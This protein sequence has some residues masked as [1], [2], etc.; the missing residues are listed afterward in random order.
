MTN[1]RRAASNGVRVAAATTGSST[2]A[3]EDPGGAR[4]RDPGEVRVDAVLARA[5]ARCRGRR[6]PSASSAA[7]NARAAA[8]LPLPAGAVEEVGVRGARPPAAARRAEDGAG[9]GMAL[10]RRRAWAPGTVGSPADGRPAGDDRG[11]RRRGQDDA[12][13][14]ARR[15]ARRAGRRARSCC[16]SPA[17]SSSPSASATLVKDPALRVGA[18]AEALMYAAARAQLV[19]ER[20]A[21]AARRGPLG[22]AR[23]LRRLVAGLPG[24]GARRSASSACASSTASPP[25][26]WSP[27][28]RCSWRSTRRRAG[29]GSPGAARRPTASRREDAAFFA[30][31]AA[32]YADLAAAEPQRMRVLD[33]GAR[34]AGG[35]RGGARRAGGPPPLAGSGSRRLADHERHGQDAVARPLALQPRVQE[36]ERRGPQ[37]LGVGRDGRQ[38]RRGQAGDVEVVEADR[39][40]AR[41]A[42]RRPRPARR[43][44][45]P[46]R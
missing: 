21:A 33:A 3:D 4:G 29:R 24:R 42:R 1:T 11:T 10:E 13:L 32:A 26:G 28:G 34:R 44:A 9:V 5:R 39:P 45:G 14:R 7:A 43:P 18:R 17:A 36:L 19:E 35:P 41:P 2:S 6:A 22:A 40:T 38:R 37:A 15:R 16:A 31:V 30:R 23:S 8:A 12:R 27:T 20:G 25:A 46:R